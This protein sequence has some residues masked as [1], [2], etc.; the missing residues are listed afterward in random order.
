[1]KNL[2]K[3]SA[4]LL[5]SVSFCGLAGPSRAASGEPGIVVCEPAADPA[6][7]SFGVGCALWLQMTVGGQPEFGRTPLWRSL[8]RARRE[9]NRPDLRLTAAQAAR[10]GPLLGVTHAA[11]GEL[12]GTGAHLSLTYRLLRVPSGAPVGAAMTLRGT[13][14]QITAGLPRLART[15]AKSL[16]AA[17]PAVPASPGLTPADL[18]LFGRF[19]WEDA[20]EV[21]A[22]KA[23][24]EAL[25][26]QSPLAGLLLVGEPV[27]S[28]ARFNAAA[29]VLIRQA[30]GNP[31]VW[32]EITEQRPLAALPQAG[33]L[34]ALAARFPGSAALAAAETY[35]FR[36]VQDRAAERRAAERAVQDSPQSPDAWLT[37]AATLDGAAQSLRQGRVYDAL[38]PEEAATLGHLYAQWEAAARRSVTLDPAFAKGWLRLAEAATFNSDPAADPAIE[39]ALR[40]SDD[41]SGV[42]AWALEMYQPKWNDDPSKLRRFSRLAAADT[43]LTATETID[44]GKELRS[45]GSPDLQQSV[46]NGF[47]VRQRAYAA[48]HPRDGNAY[49]SLAEVEKAAGQTPAAQADFRT[50]LPLLPESAG[51]RYGYGN[52]LYGPDTNAQA[53]AQFESAVQ[54][55]PEDPA[56]HYYLGYYL[57]AHLKLEDANAELQTALRLNPAYG[58]AHGALG[59]IYLR[60]NKLPEA[61]SEYRTALKLGSLRRVTAENLVFALDG[62]G[63][64]ADALT[65][66]DAMLRIYINGDGPLYDNMADAALHTKDWDKSLTFSQAALALNPNDALA[67]ENAAEADLGAGR[68]PDAQIEWR[69]VLAFSDDHL[70]TAAQ[71]YLKQYP[72][73]LP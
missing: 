27:R 21:E 38:S 50:A 1:M 64:Y 29:Q 70:K 30:G 63:R 15:L 72:E 8:A 20:A 31:L 65:A 59:E 66:G 25:A 35:R 48:A 42:Y 5:V 71:G 16:G 45:S 12:H 46:L 18:Q 56:A 2:W 23:P 36:A 49:W 17:A 44:V 7:G 67:H 52:T 32:G 57:F 58:D 55:D 4:A 40:L 37:L 60:Q 19:R 54:A 10:L 68:I 53:A 73:K 39:N 13:R 26:A 62:S 61:V 34:A 33:T 51:V 47:L 3:L 28:A 6:N 43:T 69:K 24:V 14:E 11:V 9:L 22:D 41:K